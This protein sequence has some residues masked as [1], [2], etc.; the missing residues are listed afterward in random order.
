MSGQTAGSIAAQLEANAASHGDSVWLRSPDTGASVTWAG[1][2]ASARDIASHLDALGLEAGA[3]V[4]VAA[5]NSVWSTLC[6]AGITT[7]GYLSTPLNLVSGARVLSY[8]IRHSG[9]SKCG[10]VVDLWA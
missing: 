7:G 4:A 1:A 10:T 2:L 3:P 8:V 5:Q 9:V 6:F